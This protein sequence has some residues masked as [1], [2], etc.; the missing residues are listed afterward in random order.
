MIRLRPRM[1]RPM[2]KRPH[3]EGKRMVNCIKNPYLSKNL[4]LKETRKDSLWK[5]FTRKSKK[6]FSNFKTCTKELVISNQLSL[7]SIGLW[8]IL[9]L[10]SPSS[11]KT[12]QK[13]WSLSTAPKK[14]IGISCWRKWTGWP[15]T[16][17]R[18]SRKSK[19]MPK[20]CANPPRRA[21]LRNKS[22]KKN[23]RENWSLS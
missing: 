15:T 23:S 9:T 7:R 21:F 18:N 5:N 6:F 10:R 8:A 17:R 20:N 16:S 14:L 1:S 22:P 11:S 4:W 19:Q 2:K 12:R 13:T 3:L